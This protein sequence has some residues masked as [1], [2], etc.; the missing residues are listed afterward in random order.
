MARR[1]TVSLIL[2][3]SL[4]IQ[5]S[6]ANECLLNYPAASGILY[7]GDSEVLTV[8]GCSSESI[9]YGRGYIY[10][11]YP[12]LPCFFMSCNTYNNGCDPSNSWCDLKYTLDGYVGNLFLYGDVDKYGALV[13]VSTTQS[14]PCKGGGIHTG[15]PSQ[16]DHIDLLSLHNEFEE[17]MIGFTFYSTV[18]ENLCDMN[19][20]CRTINEEVPL[21]V[22]NGYYIIEKNNRIPLDLFNLSFDAA[23]ALQGLA[24]IK[25][26]FYNH[27][28]EPFT[29][30]YKTSYFTCQNDIPGCEK[31]TATESWKLTEDT[32]AHRIKLPAWGK[33]VWF[34]D[35]ILGDPSQLPSYMSIEGWEVDLSNNRIWLNLGSFGKLYFV[36]G[37][38]S[39]N[40]GL[41]DSVLLD[42]I[43]YCPEGETFNNV[44]PKWR[45]KYEYNSS[46]QARIKYV[47][48]GNDS[49]NP[50]NSSRYYKYQ[51]TE[52][53]KTVTQE[54][55]N[56]TVS[57][58][59]PLRVETASF[60]DQSRV[61]E[62]SAGCS[63]GCSG[64]GQGYNHVAYYDEFDRYKD[65][66]KN[67]YNRN[68][69]IVLHNQYGVLSA[70]IDLPERAVGINNSGFEESLVSDGEFISG[71]P[72]G[73]ING[74]G[75][76]DSIR[77]L[78]PN[79][80]QWA[81]RYA[82]GQEIPE[83]Q[84]ILTLLGGKVQT[85]PL[86]FIVGQS[87][88]F[89]EAETGAFVD[90][91]S[92]EISIQLLAYNP[93]DPNELPVTLIS[94]NAS[95]NSDP[96]GFGTRLIPGQWVTQSGFW[97]YSEDPSMQGRLLCVAVEG[98][99]VDIDQVQLT[100]ITH[101]GGNTRPLL[102]SQQSDPNQPGE[103]NMLMVT[104]AYDSAHASAVE[105]R[106]VDNETARVIKYQ[107]T[108]NSFSIVQ[109]KTEYENL[110]E[111]PD[112]PS[113]RSY[114]TLYD[115]Y[116]EEQESET[117]YVKTT[118]YPSG[119]RK[120]IEKSYNTSGLKETCTIGTNPAIHINQ[121]QTT[122]YSNN[123]INTQVDS[124][125]AVTNYTYN[126]QG[127]LESITYPSTSA[128]QKMVSYEYDG[129]RRITKEWQDNPSK[130]K[131]LTQYYYDDPNSS[132][133]PNHYY[134]LHTGHLMKV[135]YDD[136]YS[137]DGYNLIVG[138][139]QTTEYR[140]NDFGQVTREVSP[141][142]SKSGKKY[143]LGG[144]LV[145]E[146]VIAPQE[147]ISLPDE[148]L[149]V[150]S[151][152]NYYY[153]NDGRIECIKKA[154]Y[155][156][157]F[158]FA[159]PANLPSTIKWVVTRYVYDYLGRKIAVIEDEG[160]L[161]LLTQYEYNNQ[162]EV[163]KTILPNG[164]WTEIHRNGRGQVITQ[165]IGHDQ[166]DSSLWQVTELEYDA[167]GNL[168]RQIDPSDTVTVYEY[169]EYDRLIG[170]KKGANVQ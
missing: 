1:N 98:N 146:F 55:F 18:R 64:S 113:G 49:E 157:E 114:A 59:S 144:E 148:Q 142:G 14:M 95:E 153:D 68:G 81:G 26:L 23:S 131:I 164:K 159:D 156:D 30:A 15:L 17:G 4:L 69:D 41:S 53:Q 40:D 120:D 2:F 60:D 12:Y 92:S 121:E 63:S 108:D 130:R 56:T 145:S 65:L 117:V 152:T 170:T 51:W 33:D 90:P 87:T 134:D 37:T 85:V 129:A 124:R 3:L 149:A 66:V 22:V 127:L 45:Y 48:D 128:E 10:Q 136:D 168:F 11:F 160:G 104:W 50:E 27:L 109:S 135:V 57:S 155:P 71:A 78:N 28:D 100:A 73:W 74:K 75:T 137:D 123:K 103:P 88:Y 25:S 19:C 141:N 119:K 58:S 6:L 169:D 122:Y 93:S 115:K 13:P 105:R 166:V 106:W 76:Q 52:D 84:Q 62:F 167:N 42:A 125:G 43:T 101:I 139:K 7:P 96:E 77:V 47:Y 34:G 61:I 44:Q 54:Y 46:N 9:E 112:Q 70:G 29:Y 39:N 163:D 67:K 31:Q 8:D 94:I 138:S 151:Q 21:F 143:G 118:T 20:L 36:L 79:P 162:G 80:S 133:D 111:N 24:S 161:S 99:R 126:G 107:Y 82:E 147:D 158:P 38:P 35:S 140:Y 91:N 16:I 116:E 83:G 102:F 86:G 154:D 72:S 110:N 150:L 97:N 89:F 32:T 5:I 165:I 132:E